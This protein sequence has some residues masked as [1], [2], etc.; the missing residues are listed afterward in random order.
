MTTITAGATGSFTFT[1]S[2]NAAS[3]TLD[4]GVR[5]IFTVLSSAGAM[6][7][8]DNVQASRVLGPYPV[9]SVM[10]LTAIGGSVD[11]TAVDA[12]N[13]FSSPVGVNSDN[14]VTDST[15]FPVSG[16][17]NAPRNVVIVGDSRAA[18]N[19]SSGAS[20]SNG[21]YNNTQGMVAWANAM[22]GQRMT[23]V[24]NKAVSGSQMDGVISRLS[25]DIDP[26]SFDWLVLI[27]DLNDVAAGR[28]ADA[29]CA[30]YET[31]YA[32]AHAR[33]A[34]V[35]HVAPYAPSVALTAAQSQVLLQVRYY[36]L[37]SPS[38]LGHVYT[39]DAMS[40]IGDATTSPPTTPAAYIIDPAGSGFHFNGAGAF[41][42]AEK[43]AE[44]W[45]QY[46]PEAPSLLA[47]AADNYSVDSTVARPNLFDYGL[48]SGNAGTNGTGS[49]SAPS[50]ITATVY[51]AGALSLNGGN[52]YTTA[53]GGTSGATAPTHTSGSASDGGVIWDHVGTGAVT[54]PATGWTVKR[55][56][57]A[58]TGYT[59]T[60][61]RADGV[62]KDLVVAV[63]G[64]GATDVW[65]ISPSTTSTARAALG[66]TYQPEAEISL[67]NC[68]GLCAPTLRTL[69]TVSGVTVQ[70]RDLSASTTLTNAVVRDK[71]IRL[72]VPS[73]TLPSSG[74]I[75]NLEGQVLLTFGAAS[76]RAVV[77]LGRASLRK[78][79]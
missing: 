45:S 33:G 10:S 72:R 49:N 24:A 41:L 13:Y 67:I 26:L 78:I 2:A 7:A 55:N 77:K 36:I 27:C 42:L 59:C 53:A 3:I 18:Q 51:A 19:N 79:A 37:S 31:F 8:S 43:I 32:Y 52:A 17:G 56:A 12:D 46:V 23:I 47:S 62:G 38:R 1:S 40:I 9:G 57:G 28:T 11:Y 30:D 65:Q 44:I 70:S 34:R 21:N 73:I 29:I 20:A 15:G 6:I 66:G 54:G 58:G 4:P 22:C 25:S 14:Q 71:T 74:S 60:V 39:V 50:W 61:N 75:T 35:I 64:A 16:G 76:A 68:S 5:A 63:T 69:T 48:F